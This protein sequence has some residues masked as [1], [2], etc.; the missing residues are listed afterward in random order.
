MAPFRK[1][2]ARGVVNDA[3]RD[4]GGED[5]VDR[6]AQV[7]VRGHRVPEALK[8]RA[9]EPRAGHGRQPSSVRCDSAAS[10]DES[11][12]HHGAGQHVPFSHQPVQG[13]QLHVH[14]E[15]HGVVDEP[16]DGEV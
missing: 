14:G 8:D 6:D 13:F 11:I 1:R 3:K 12:E 4:D 7:H 15:T 10:L 5:E 9:F 16:G 2:H